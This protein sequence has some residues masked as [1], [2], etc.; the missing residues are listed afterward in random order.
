MYDLKEYF[1][2][3]S[4]VIYRIR[5]RIDCFTLPAYLCQNHMTQCYLHWLRTGEGPDY[6]YNKTYAQA[7]H[8]SFVVLHTSGGAG[9]PKPAILN[10][11]TL[12]HHDLFLNAR[13]LDGKTLNLARFGGTRVLLCLPQFHSASVCF[14]AF[15]LYSN[16]IPVLSPLPV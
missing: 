12:A 14:S 9:L 6:L 4:R 7:K 16:T 8:E 1:S 10:H 2:S 13:S 11:G 5:N 3:C 15:S